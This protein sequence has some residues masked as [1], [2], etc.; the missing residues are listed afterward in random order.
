M[1]YHNLKQEEID[2]ENGTIE[3]MKVYE[4]VIYDSENVIKCERCNNVIFY[5]ENEMYHV[6][7]YKENED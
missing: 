3:K 2:Y 5:I 1:L 6:C 4:N 7:P